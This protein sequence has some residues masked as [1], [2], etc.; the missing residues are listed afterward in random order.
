MRSA[1]K[2]FLSAAG[3]AKG[4]RGA[5]VCMFRNQPPCPEA[6]TRAEKFASTSCFQRLRQA[7]FLPSQPALTSPSPKP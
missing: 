1:H 5:M 4:R 2:G 6:P 7:T 3:L